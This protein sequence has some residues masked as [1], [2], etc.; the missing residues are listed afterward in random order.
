MLSCTGP[1][2][3]DSADQEQELSRWDGSMKPETGSAKSTTWVMMFHVY[4]MSTL[5]PHD[6][7]H[8]LSTFYSQPRNS[9]RR[10]SSL[11][12]KAPWCKNFPNLAKGKRETLQ[13]KFK[14]QNSFP[15]NVQKK[16]RLFPVFSAFFPGFSAFFRLWYFH[17]FF[18]PACHVVD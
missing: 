16:I 5:C 1:H 13:K 7:D 14:T 12:R 4:H 2:A 17:F 15:K 18:C 11:M 8:P 3:K 6:H 10:A 9:H